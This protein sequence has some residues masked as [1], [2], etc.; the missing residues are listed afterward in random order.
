MCLGR[1]ENIAGQGGSVSAVHELHDLYKS[2]ALYI[3]LW[4][5]ND[6]DL[7]SS[8]RRNLYVDYPSPSQIIS[9]HMA[10]CFS[11][12]FDCALEK[13]SLAHARSFD[14][15][16]DRCGSESWCNLSIN[17]LNELSSIRNPAELKID[18]MVYFNNYPCLAY[19]ITKTKPPG[20][21]ER[22]MK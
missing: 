13:I 19:R 6:T 22:Y 1:S 4:D 3:E 14:M 15:F 12:K 8:M 20:L 16:R 18:A 7:P 2:S 21:Q 17:K 5:F 10:D 11:A 9:A